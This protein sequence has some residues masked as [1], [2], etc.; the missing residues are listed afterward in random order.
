LL[1][2]IGLIL[3]DFLI[4]VVEALCEPSLFIAMVDGPFL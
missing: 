1:A 4:G 2:A 3:V